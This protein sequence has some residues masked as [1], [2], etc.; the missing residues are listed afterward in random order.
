MG[1]GGKSTP[2]KVDP[3]QQAQANVAAQQAALPG[4]YAINDQMLRQYLGPQTQLREDVRQD[5]FPGEQA[6]RGQLQQNI[7][8][9][10]ISPQGATPQQ[11]EAQE[12]IRNRE[13]ER[14][15]RGIQTSANVGGTLFGGRRQAREDRAMTELGQ[16]Y[17]ESDITRDDQRRLNAISSAMPF[18]QLLFPGSQ[19][20]QPQFI[21]PVASANTQYGGAVSQRGQDL[22]Y[23]AAQQAN[24]SALWGSLMKG[25]GSAAGGFLGGA[26]FDNFMTPTAVGGIK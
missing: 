21:N 3:T 9:S 15:Q 23:Q 22:T 10:L 2:E 7:L 1:G 11:L 14:L 25:V 8:Q 16:A 12:A 19:I 5:V 20:S 26:A 24:Q 17:A 18:L 13:Q 4:A 6:V